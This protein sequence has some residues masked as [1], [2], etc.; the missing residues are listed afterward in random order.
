LESSDVHSIATPFNVAKQ[1]NKIDEY[2]ATSR[3]VMR[4]LRGE[5]GA[6]LSPL[7]K[8]RLELDDAWP[9]GANVCKHEGRP[10]LAGLPRV[11]HGPTK[12]LQ[13]FC[14]VDDISPCVAGK[15]LFSANVYLETPPVGGNLEIWPVTWRSKEAF[16]KH[17]ELIQL[18]TMQDEAA[19]TRLRALLPKPIEIQ[20]LAGDLIILC[21]KRPHAV[22]GF[23]FGT[24]VSVQS[25]VSISK[26]G[27]PMTLD[28]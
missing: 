8:L 28:V 6:I 10:F 25:F 22:Q 14:H 7:D 12:W 16:E 1:L 15:G 26:E 21:A 19:Q 4:I 2:F 3:E 13:G 18:F 5:E 17:F 27:G 23:A 24:R 11:M 9:A 20:V